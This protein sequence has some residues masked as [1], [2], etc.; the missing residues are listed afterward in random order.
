MRRPIALVLILVGCSASLWGTQLLLLRAGGERVDARVVEVETSGPTT[1][2]QRQRR[3][4][5][6]P[7][8]YFRLEI[9]VA[10]AFD[11][12]PTPAEAL[13]RVSNEPLRRDVRGRDT[14]HYKVRS[15]DA[16]PVKVGDTVGV[17][18]WRFL[19]SVNVA[20]QPRSA[21]VEGSLA[22]GSGMVLLVVGWFLRP[23]ASTVPAKA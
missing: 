10:Y 14:L 16:L 5:G 20:D 23:R 3:S 4:T 13:A 11:V 19:P 2:I 8:G 15:A 17:R 12:L 9:D 1:E 21:L 7:T 18:Y 6:R 22:L